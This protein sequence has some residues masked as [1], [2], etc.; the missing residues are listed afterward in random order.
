[1]AYKWHFFTIKDIT[2][3][4]NPVSSNEPGTDQERPPATMATHPT[5]EQRTR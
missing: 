5:D 3:G 4:I 1:M 2:P